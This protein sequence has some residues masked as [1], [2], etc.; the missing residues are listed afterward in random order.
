MR[1]RFRYISS[2]SFLI[3]LLIIFQA[4]GQEGDPEPVEGSE[5]ES[6]VDAVADSVANEVKMAASDSI[7]TDNAGVPDD[8]EE[9]DDKQV[10]SYNRFEIGFDYLKLLTL[11]FSTETKMEAGLG[12]ISK[13]NIGINIEVGY[14]EKTPE[15]FYKNAEYKAYGYYGRAGLSYYYPFNPTTNFIIGIK[16]AMSQYQD[17]ATFSILSTL[18]DDFEDGFQREDL[19]ASWAELILGSEAAKWGNLY[20]GFT[21][22]LRFLIQADNFDPFEVYF[23]P[24]YGRTFDKF[25]PALNLYVKYVIPFGRG[26]AS[27]KK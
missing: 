14:G 16:Y 13:Y 9:P 18:W 11:L 6:V 23:I 7:V 27:T 22:R 20:F 17:E 15:D 12:F 8:T 21:F 10:R 3:L 1:L 5:T 26:R 25:V 4:T 19:E 24:G 2:I